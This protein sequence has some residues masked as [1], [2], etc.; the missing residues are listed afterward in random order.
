MLPGETT[1]T[2][3]AVEC[4]TGADIAVVITEWNEFRAL[5]LDRVKDLLKAP[6]MV[7]LRNIYNPQDMADAGFEYTCIGRAKLAAEG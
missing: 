6:V 1:F 4:L 3:S 7:D 2:T 5:D